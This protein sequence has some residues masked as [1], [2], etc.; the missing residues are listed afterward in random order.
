MHSQPFWSILVS[1]LTTTESIFCTTKTRKGQKCIK[2]AIS[3][4]FRLFYLTNIWLKGLKKYILHLQLKNHK[5]SRYFLICMELAVNELWLRNQIKSNKLHFSAVLSYS[6]KIFYS[7][8]Y[9]TKPSKHE[10]L[11]RVGLHTI[12]SVLAKMNSCQVAEP[13]FFLW[14]PSINGNGKF[15]LKWN[16][17]SFLRWCKLDNI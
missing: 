8:N 12:I 15:S 16:S 3:N 6:R 13:L 10:Q 1:H 14:R 9:L 17:I 7:P 4:L 11:S 2:T 5:T